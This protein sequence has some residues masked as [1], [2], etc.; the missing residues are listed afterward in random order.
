MNTL[1]NKSSDTST[2]SA[3]R[4]RKTK[5]LEEKI[6]ALQEKINMNIEKSVFANR[7]WKRMYDYRIR[8]DQKLLAKYKEKLK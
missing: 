3:V 4:K 1:T 8:R 6:A 7:S 5:T 2:V